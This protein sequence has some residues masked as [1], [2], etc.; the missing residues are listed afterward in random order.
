MKI[1]FSWLCDN[2]WRMR[3]PR[4]A[5]CHLPILDRILSA[6][7]RK[8]HPACFTCSSCDTCL[9]G[10]QFVVDEE[11]ET[12]ICRSCYVSNRAPVCHKCCEP[13]VS[14]P[15]MRECFQ[16]FSDK[17]LNIFREESNCDHMQWE[18]ISSQ[19]LHMSS[20]IHNF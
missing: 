14:D 11:T 9:D 13:I 5:H 1:F 3:Q 4:C 19:M 15:G 16:I 17:M 7:D 6:Q 8:Y 18:Q 10:G 12:V 2:D 20:R